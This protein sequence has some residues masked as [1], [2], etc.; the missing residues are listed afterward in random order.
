MAQASSSDSATINFHSEDLQAK[1][2]NGKVIKGS[3]ETTTN[4][5]KYLR[6][7]H[8]TEYPA[9]TK[10]KTEKQKKKHSLEVALSSSIN[11]AEFNKRVVHFIIHTILAV[12]IIDHS[13][14]KATFEEFNVNVMGRKS[15]MTTIQKIFKLHPDDLKMQIGKQR[16]LCSTAD[17]WASKRSFMEVTMHSLDDKLKRV[18]VALAFQRFRG[19]HNYK[20][21]EKLD[22]IYVKYGINTNQ[23][24]ATV[25]DNASNFVKAFSEFT[26]QTSAVTESKE[27][28]SLS[29]SDSDKFDA[30]LMISNSRLFQMSVLL[31]QKLNLQSCYQSSSSNVGVRTKH[32]HA[33][34]KSRKLWAK[35]GRPETAEII[36]EI[37]G[38]T[39]SCPGET[40][41]N[42]YFDCISRILHEDTN[43]KL[44]T[45]HQKLG[46]P[47]LK[48]TEI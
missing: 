26:S 41:W 21:I 22:Y 35:T 20:N 4:F 38:R 34:N 33:I 40:R 9:Y 37:L 8:L 43:P 5:V 12:S 13:S 46:L 3:V 1:V 18:F 7:I 24:I 27:K 42:S 15:A 30:S 29:V 31:Q 45:L 36:M 48:E 14:F 28:V 25:T 32:M 23:I 2:V 6:R 19:Y 10:Y 44:A 17:I 39:L 47:H 16:F 11:Q